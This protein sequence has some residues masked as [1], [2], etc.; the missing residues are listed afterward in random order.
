M[1]ILSD[2]TIGGIV[3][4]PFKWGYGTVQG[5]GGDYVRRPFIS[6]DNLSTVRTPPA[7]PYG[8]HIEKPLAFFDDFITTARNQLQPFFN[9]LGSASKTNLSEMKGVFDELFN[10]AVKAKG[11]GLLGLYVVGG[12]AALIMGTKLAMSSWHKVSELDKGY[13]GV[14]N[15]NSMWIHGLQGAG[16]LGMAAGVGLAVAGAPIGAPMLLAGTALSFVM[17]GVRHAIGGFHPGNYTEQ[18]YF[19]FNHIANL[20]NNGDKFYSPK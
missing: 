19:P 17:F 10:G 1:F 6:P 7:T 12:A 20:F 4:A 13:T 2:I 14:D 16:G 8:S 3:A 18:L 9:K 15:V 5:I 11:A